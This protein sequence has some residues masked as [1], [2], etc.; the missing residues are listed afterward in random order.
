MVS[1]VAA[2]LTVTLTRAEDECGPVT[3]AAEPVVLSL[4]GHS[5]VVTVVPMT[6]V[7]VPLVEPVVASAD[8]IAEVDGE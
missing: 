3:A 7:S 6:V 1:V 4:S 5:V 2:E 8:D